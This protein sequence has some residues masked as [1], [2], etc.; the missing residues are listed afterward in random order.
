[1]LVDTILKDDGV[2]FSLFSGVTQNDDDE[3]KELARMFVLSAIQTVSN[4][5]G[6]DANAIKEGTEIVGEFVEIKYT[7]TA[8]ALLK[9]VVMRIATLKQQEG[10][11]NIGVNASSEFGTNRNYLNIVN[12]EPYLQPLATFRLIGSLQKIKGADE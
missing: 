9:N 2:L 8:F 1:M 12:Y 3:H 4:Y 10:G 7:D 11:G 5:V 6:Y